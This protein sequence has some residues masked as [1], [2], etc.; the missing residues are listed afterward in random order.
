MKLLALSM[1]KNEEFWI[2]MP[3]DLGPRVTALAAAQ[4]AK[5][6]TNFEKALALEPQSPLTRQNLAYC[7]VQLGRPQDAEDLFRHEGSRP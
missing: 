3:D 6:T 7:Y 5:G 1:V 4:T 2:E